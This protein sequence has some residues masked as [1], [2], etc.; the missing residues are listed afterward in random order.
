MS[1]AHSGD[2]LAHKLNELNFQAYELK[3]L[4]NDNCNQKIRNRAVEVMQV[5]NRGNFKNI[6]VMAVLLQVLS[7]AIADAANIDDVQPVGNATALA[8]VDM[9]NA[10]LA[11]RKG[12]R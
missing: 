9:V 1:D 10:R 3:K 4:L 5:L 12:L 11:I 2:N 6:E 7:A 8:L